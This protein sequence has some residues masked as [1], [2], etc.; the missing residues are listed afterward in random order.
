M[1]LYS[2]TE[3][4]SASILYAVS[5]SP[6]PLYDLVSCDDIIITSPQYESN[7]GDWQYLYIDLILIFAF[8]VVSKS[9]HSCQWPVL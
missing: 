2:L 9:Q 3:F 8:S 6:L 1:A 7:L 4:I 5:T